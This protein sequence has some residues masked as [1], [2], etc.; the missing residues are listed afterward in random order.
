MNFENSFFCFTLGIIFIILLDT[1][2]AIASNKFKFKY[3][4][5][6]PLS[7]SIYIYTGYILAKV[8]NYPVSLLYVAI[9]GVFDGTIGL[10]L[11][12]YFK[13]NMG[14]DENE[15]QKMQNLQTTLTMAIVGSIFGSIGFAISTY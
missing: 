13:A 2:G 15:I 5:L 11:S 8:I 6:A 1:I 3:I 14:L 10:K 12:I 9:L 7:L 4:H